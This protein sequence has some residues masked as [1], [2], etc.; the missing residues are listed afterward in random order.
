MSLVDAPL[1]A[2]AVAGTFNELSLA[3]EGLP[4]SQ[5][6]IVVKH[7]SR[8]G[9]GVGHWIAPTGALNPRVVR[10]ALDSV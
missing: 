2:A 6:A 8:R 3:A 1:D 10:V 5:T 7:D 9:G 4:Q